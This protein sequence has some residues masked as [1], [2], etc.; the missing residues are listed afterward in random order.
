MV[1]ERTLR[2]GMVSDTLTAVLSMYSAG[3]GAKSAQVILY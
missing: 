2:L 1:E 3:S